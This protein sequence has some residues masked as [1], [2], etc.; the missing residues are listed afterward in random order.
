M[1]APFYDKIRGVGLTYDDVLLVP[2]R[3]GVMPRSVNTASYLTRSIRLNVPLV[4]AAMDTVTEAQLAIAIAREGGVGVLHKNMP[5]DRQIAEVRRV[6]RSESGMIMDPITLTPEATVADAHS[7]MSRNSIGG[8]PITDEQGRLVGIV[9]NR[10]LRFQLNPSVALS[11]I[12][13]RD[14]LVTAPEGTTLEAAEALLQQNK[15]EKLPVVDASG[16]LRGLITFKDIEKKRKY[17]LAAKDEHGRLRVGA[18]VGVTADILDRVSALVEA[19][20]DFVTIDTAH[21][22]SEGVLDAVRTVRSHFPG[23]QIVAGNVATA[24]ATEDIIDA[25]ADGVKVGIGPGSI[26]TTRV[27]AGVGVPQLSAILECAAVARPRGIPIIADGGIKQTGDVP[28]ALAAGASTV[29]IGGM[30][31][32]VE[33]SPGETILY[34]G[35]KFK[36]YRGMGSIGAMRDG[37]SD[38]YFQDAEDGLNKLVPEGIEGRV[39][40]SG[41]LGEV[42]YQIVGGLRAAM[43]YTGCSD[44]EALAT[45]AQFIQV[46]DSGVREGHPH[47]VSIT[48]ESPN[49]SSRSL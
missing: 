35:R 5:I 2:A 26:C 13:T 27:V 40:Y 24:E 22:H 37:S 36:S 32:R 38:R 23:L 18:A 31:A 4:S 17:P 28:K 20:V 39:P 45:N 43:G 8:I 12:M 30:F 29:M 16:H 41:T 11:E 44:I 49:Y 47:D 33:E 48:K 14:R 21:G 25:G 42:V 7:M 9:T 34:E 19:E 46:T 1:Q 3:S 6:K 10:D 15:I